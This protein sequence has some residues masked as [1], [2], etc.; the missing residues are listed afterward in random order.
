[1]NRKSADALT[2]LFRA[3]SHNNFRAET[4]GEKMIHHKEH[5]VH[6]GN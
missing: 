2:S 6:K 1:M 4:R 5:E 3:Q